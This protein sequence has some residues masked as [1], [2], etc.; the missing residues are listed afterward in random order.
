MSVQIAL[1]VPTVLVD[2]GTAR[3]GARAAIVVFSIRPGGRSYFMSVA[4]PLEQLA[5]TF[6]GR[7]LQPADAGYDDARRVHNGLIDKRPA[8]IARCH[9]TADVADA[10]KLART[11]NLEIA[12]RGGGHNVGGPRHH[13]RRP[14]DRS[15]ADEGHPCLPDGPHRARAG[16]RALEGVQ[17][18]DAAPRPGDDRW[19]RRH[20]RHRRS[21]AR[22]RPGLA[23]A[24]VRARAR[25]PASRSRS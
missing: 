25:Q 16:R 10:V 11:L 19:R 12:V 18:R 3:L 21:D 1:L 23:D 13:R 17:S 7:L 14:D 2:H 9:G 4:T 24:E 20:D 6:T 15:R 8:L 22:R 5:P